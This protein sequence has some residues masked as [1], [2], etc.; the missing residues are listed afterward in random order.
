VPHGDALCMHQARR[1]GAQVLTFGSAAAAA[2]A[3][4]AKADVEVQADAIVD[5]RTQTRFAREA[6]ALAGGHNAQNLAAAIAVAPR[7]G[8]CA[9]TIRRV[10]ATFE[11]LPHRMR[12]LRTVLGVRYYDDSKGTNVGA[13]VTALTGLAEPRVVLIAGGKD[14]GGGYGALAD[15][16]ASKG[17]ALILIGEAAPLIAEAAVGR[18]PI[19]RAENM[20]DAVHL[21]QTHARPGD[22]VL[23]S[24]ACSSFDMYRDYKERGDVFAHAVSLLQEPAPEMNMYPEPKGVGL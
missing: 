4:A 7:L 20:Q 3:A 23:L 9:E 1:G 18:L 10:F 12:Y 11:G 15:A 21:A 19:E 6:C 2:A 13:A 5:H 24:P 17:R 8:A 14:K 22:A 16:L